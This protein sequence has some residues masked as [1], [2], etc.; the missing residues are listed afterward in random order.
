MA[1][2]LKKEQPEKEPQALAPID[3]V[4]RELHL[5]R[6]Q[7]EAVLPKHL[8]PDRLCRLAILACEKTPKLLRCDRTS[9][10]G[11]ILTAAQLGLEPD[12]I[13]GQAYLVPYGDKVQ[14]IP[15]YRGLIALAR[16]SGEVQ[17][18]F[19][20]AVHE[21]DHFAYRFGINEELDHIPSLAPDRGDKPI[22]HFYALAR[23]INGGRHF[24]VMT[25]SEVERIRNN[26]AGFKSGGDSPW[27][28]H[29][30]EMGKKTAIRRI[31]KYLP[32]NV[33]RAAALA[34]AYDRG[35]HAHIDESGEVREELAA[36][37]ESKQLA[38]GSFL[39]QFEGGGEKAIDIEKVEVTT[40][41]EPGSDDNAQAATPQGAT[42]ADY[43]DIEERAKK[44]GMT[45]VA[46]EALC[47]KTCGKALGEL[48]RDDANAVI[49]ELAKK[50]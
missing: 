25:R 48:S 17:S 23:F 5:R 15:G 31:A 47:M 45:P 32:M 50:G 41:R 13:L 34:D 9:L 35:M 40:E 24:D 44:K 42:E 49:K 39:D 16:Q 20:G 28:S 7:L 2:P 26:S 19:A 22:T 27:K 30:E 43:C 37:R 36:A 6:R 1:E 18:I 10:Y 38:A 21:G 11:A 33:Q 3:M 4:R 8:T 46:L 12:G 29:F 14:F